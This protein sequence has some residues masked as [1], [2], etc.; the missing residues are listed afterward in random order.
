MAAMAAMMIIVISISIRVN[1]PPLRKKGRGP[2][3]PFN[4]GY[5]PLRFVGLV[6]GALP[7]PC[8]VSPVR[9]KIEG[10]IIH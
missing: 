5:L 6:N 1:P 7:G 3:A 8:F 2:Q 9:G 10:V 4:I